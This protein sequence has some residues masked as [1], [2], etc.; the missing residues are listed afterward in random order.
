[1]RLMQRGNFKEKLTINQT[2]QVTLK[3]QLDRLGW[4]RV[5]AFIGG[6]AIIVISNL[7][8]QM[9]GYLVGF[10]LLVFFTILVRQYNKTDSK[11]R[12]YEA[13]EKV[14]KEYLDRISDK[15]KNFEENGE[16]YQGNKS[17]VKDLDLLGR[18]SLYQYICIAHTPFGKKALA[19]A[20]IDGHKEKE[21]IL[22]RQQAV[23]E[24]M[25]D[26]EFALHLQTLSMQMKLQGDSTTKKNLEEFIIEAEKQK[27]YVSRFMKI[28]SIVLPFITLFALVIWILGYGWDYTNIVIEIGVILQ[29]LIVFWQM[30]STS[31]IFNPI[32][33]FNKNIGV[34]KE[35][36]VAIEEKSFKS[37]YLKEL[38]KQLLISGSP[39]QGIESLN[40]LT[41]S[42]KLRHNFLAN[43]LLN[44]LVMWD[45]HCKDALGIWNSRYGNDIRK[46]LEIIGEV[47]VLVSLAVIGRVKK[48]YCFPHIIDSRVPK[49]QFTHLAHPLITEEKA[50]GNSLKMEETTCII[51]GSNMSGKTTFLRS[52]GVNLALAYAGAPVVAETFS[53]SYMEVFTSMRIEDRVDE[54]ISTFYAELLRIK[55]MIEYGERHLPM[56]V[57]IDEI[58][59]G[60]NSADRILG[61][62]ET[63]KKLGKPWLNVMVTTHDFEL[64]NLANESDRNTVNYHFEE[65]YKDNH[66]QFDYKLKDG[67]CKTTNAKYLL[68]MV[69]I[70]DSF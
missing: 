7:E 70:L 52:I 27:K 40:K 54:G 60:T 19:K 43:I 57:L 5:L 65:Y 25:E 32:F 8:H 45:V 10:I 35:F 67:R 53:T 62:R 24:L 12:Y 28:L 38:Q 51:T 61:A 23:K 3:K 50:V 47:E 29:L 20:L 1:M 56:L 21:I 49:I 31:I 33:E 64:C 4:L 46:W 36:L 22:K 2:Q 39:V 41:D 42:I 9:I 15:W 69:G 13:E 17:R 6:V 55:E 66:I 30:R 59:K 18:S 11:K 34:Y 44:G 63:I 58:F 68:K 37:S 26:E 14:L 16:A 48:N